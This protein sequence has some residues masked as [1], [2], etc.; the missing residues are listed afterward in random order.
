MFT[1]IIEGIGKIVEKKVASHGDITISIAPPFSPEECA[2]GESIAVDGVCLTITKI[3]D[4]TISMDVSGETL[5]RST[6]DML[7]IGDSVNIERA[8]RVSDRLGGHL[9]LGHVDGIGR[10]I[11]KEKKRGSWLIRIELDKSL[12]KY[13]VEKGSIAVDGISLTVNRVEETFFEV[14]IIPET[15]MQTTLLKKRIEFVNIETDIIGKYIEKFL[16]NM[17]LKTSDS[18]ITLETLKKYGFIR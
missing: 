5:K 14:N 12:C 13:I 15:L 11:S 9:V 3:K 16:S 10:I 18:K 7:D 8:L 6:L 17:S 1:G 4:D 2:I